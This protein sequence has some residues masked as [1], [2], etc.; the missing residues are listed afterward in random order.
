MKKFP[1]KIFKRPPSCSITYGGQKKSGCHDHR[2]NKG[3]DR[4]PAQKHGDM[5]RK[6]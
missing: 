1:W 2:F 3:D 4:T 6:K 5:I